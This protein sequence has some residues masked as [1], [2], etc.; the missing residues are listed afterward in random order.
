MF[1]ANMHE[2]TLIHQ[3]G[4]FLLKD[5]HETTPTGNILARYFLHT[6]DRNLTF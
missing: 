5:M 1:V 3:Y 4:V 2:A 6:W